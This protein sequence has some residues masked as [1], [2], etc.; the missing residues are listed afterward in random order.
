MISVVIVHTWMIFKCVQHE[1]Y[2]E[3]VIRQYLMG[4]FNAGPNSALFLGV[5]LIRAG[6]RGAGVKWAILKMQ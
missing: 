2:N 3:S 4:P 1:L 5:A 6:V